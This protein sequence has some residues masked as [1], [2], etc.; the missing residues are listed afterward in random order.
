MATLMP[1]DLRGGSDI[2]GPLVGHK[3]GD[4]CSL[5]RS[6]Q[7]ACDCGVIPRSDS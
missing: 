4:D 3:H 2:F 5:Q 1:E 6:P 7:H